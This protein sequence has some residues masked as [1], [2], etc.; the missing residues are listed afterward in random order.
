MTKTA[1]QI[2]EGAGRFGQGEMYNT[3]YAKPKYMEALGLW[4]EAADEEGIGRAELGFRWIAH[5]S[6]LDASGKSGDAL[7]VGATKPEQLNSTIEY[8]KK[9]PLS[10]KAVAKI[11][12]IWQLV[13]NEAPIDNFAQ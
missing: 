8:V 4:G 6:A 10:D 11:D 5:H 7:V 2:K 12:K 3:L 9:G 1:Q 13:K